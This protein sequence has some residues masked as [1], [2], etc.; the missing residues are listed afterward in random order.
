M[1]KHSIGT[2]AIVGIVIITMMMTTIVTVCAEE[3]I[4]QRA[5]VLLIYDEIENVELVENLVTALGKT[6]TSVYEKN[7]ETIKIDNFEFVLLLTADYF[8]TIHKTGKPVFCIGSGF[9][10]P[11]V[12]TQEMPPSGIE[13]RTETFYEYLVN[14]DGLEII[15]N[16]AGEA[17]HKIGMSYDRQYPFA[18]RTENNIYYAPYVDKSNISPIVLGEVLAVFLS[19]GNEQNEYDGKVYLIINEV[20]G[21]SDLDMLCKMSDELYLANIPFI[22]KVMPIY[23]NTDLPAFDRYTQALRY[24]ES[25]NG[26]IVMSP[27]MVNGKATQEEI[28]KVSNIATKAL[29]DEEVIVLPSVEGVYEVTMEDLIDVKSPFK[30]YS[31][32][33]FDVGIVEQIPTTDL[34]LEQMVANLNGRWYT[35]GDYREK[36]DVKSHLFVETPF[37]DEY[38]GNNTVAEIPKFFRIGNDIVIVIVSVFMVI[39][40]LLVYISRKVYSKKFKRK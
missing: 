6:I 35:F 22:V 2:I 21:F 11:G 30:F 14:V 25:R 15:T 32:F 20:F 33:S 36:Y 8:E 12:E 29:T 16:F 23:K 40:I 18:I 4:K 39:M 34:Q 17:F 19:N 7:Y 5:D 9:S 31:S 24:V 1:K 27:P 3:P 38:E 13:L 26:A 37:D 10:I 28:L